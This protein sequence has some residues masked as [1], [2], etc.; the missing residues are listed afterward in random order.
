MAATIK[1][2]HYRQ[3]RGHRLKKLAEVTKAALRRSRFGRFLASGL[4]TDC[5]KLTGSR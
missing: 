5:S 2:A 1:L 4:R 3:D